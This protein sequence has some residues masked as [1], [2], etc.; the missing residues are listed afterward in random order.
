VTLEAGA[1]IVTTPVIAAWTGADW[2]LAMM[3]DTGLSVVYSVYAFVFG[4]GYDRLFP[5]D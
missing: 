5:I 4:F 1:V 3:Q 2:K